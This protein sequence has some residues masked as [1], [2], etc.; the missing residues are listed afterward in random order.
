MYTKLVA[1]YEE[2]PWLK[3]IKEEIGDPKVV[4]VQKFGVDV[5]ERWVGEIK[6][7]GDT[8]WFRGDFF[9]KDGAHLGAVKIKKDFWLRL[10][11][12]FRALLSPLSRLFRKDYINYVDYEISDKVREVVLA[13]TEMDEIRYVVLYGEGANHFQKLQLYVYKLPKNKVMS[14]IIELDKRLRLEKNAE[15]LAYKLE[16]HK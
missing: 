14:D 10:Q 13:H 11:D 4:K 3:T 7:P 9:G 16:P 2:F 15:A 6:I 8:Y 5:L 1:L 12:I